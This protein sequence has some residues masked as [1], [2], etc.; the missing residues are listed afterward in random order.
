M[1]VCSEYT[2]RQLRISSARYTALDATRLLP[3]WVVP[4]YAMCERPF[5]YASL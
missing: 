3:F 1:R 4:M 5:G 2:P